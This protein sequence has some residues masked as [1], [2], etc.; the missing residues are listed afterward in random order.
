MKKSA[1]RV[2]IWIPI[3]CLLLMFSFG[4]G[5]PREK[6]VGQYEAAQDEPVDEAAVFLELKE[7]GHAVQ[8]V[9]DDEVSF[10]WTV[11][12]NEIRLHAKTGGIIIGLIEGEAI[13]MKVPGKGLMVFRRIDSAPF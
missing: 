8:R 6:L 5:P 9:G 1:C 7:D 10:R 11:K 12:D 13:K 2:K 3:A 4:C